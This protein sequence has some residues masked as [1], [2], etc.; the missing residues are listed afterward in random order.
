LKAIGMSFE[1]ELSLGESD[2][3]LQLY[4]KCLA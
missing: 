4:A 1:K 2:E 3:I